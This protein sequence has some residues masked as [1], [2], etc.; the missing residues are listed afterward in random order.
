LLKP[1]FHFISPSKFE[2][3]QPFKT[4]YAL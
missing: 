2:L 4:E 1:A 3:R